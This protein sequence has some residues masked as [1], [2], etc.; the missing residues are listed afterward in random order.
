MISPLSPQPRSFEK[1]VSYIGITKNIEKVIGEIEEKT[2]IVKLEHLLESIWDKTLETS[3]LLFL[4][5]KKM[6][7]AVPKRTKRKNIV[8]W[9]EAKNRD[10]ESKIIRRV[11]LDQNN[12]I[13]LDS[14]ILA[15]AI[16][17]YKVDEDEGIN[18]NNKN[19]GYWILSRTSY[20]ERVHMIMKEAFS[21][22]YLEGFTHSIVKVCFQGAST[23]VKRS[24]YE[25]L[26]LPGKQEL[27]KRAEYL[28]K[29]CG[30]PE[31]DIEG[32]AR[33]VRCDVSVEDKNIK[34]KVK[35]LSK[36]IIQRKNTDKDEIEYL[37]RLARRIAVQGIT[38][39]N[40]ETLDS[41][42]KKGNGEKAKGCS[43]RIGA[44]IPNAGILLQY[45]H[46]KGK[47]EACGWFPL[48]F[49][50]LQEGAYTLNAVRDIDTDEFGCKV[51]GAPLSHFKPRI[52]C[53]MIHKG[54]K[55]II[56]GEIYDLKALGKEEFK[57][58]ENMPLYLKV[59]P[60]QLWPL[61]G[62]KEEEKDKKGKKE[63]VQKPCLP[64]QMMTQCNK[65]IDNLNDKEKSENSSKQI[66]DNEISSD[67]TEDNEITIEQCIGEEKN[68]KGSSLIEEE[69]GK[70]ATKEKEKS[71]KNEEKQENNVFKSP[72]PP[73]IS[74]APSIPPIC[75]DFTPPDPS[76]NMLF[77]S[78]KM[79]EINECAQHDTKERE[80]NF[81]QNNAT[82]AKT[83]ADSIV[84]NPEDNHIVET[85]GII[86]N[87]L[88]LKCVKNNINNSTTEHAPTH[89]NTYQQL[90]ETSN[91]PPSL[92][93]IE[94]EE[95]EEQMSSYEN[96]KKSKIIDE[97]TINTPC[98]S[99]TINTAVGGNKNQVQ[100]SDL[101]MSRNEFEEEKREI[102]NL[103]PDLNKTCNTNTKTHNNTNEESS[104]Y[105]SII[106]PTN[107]NTVNSLEQFGTNKISLNENFNKNHWNDNCARNTAPV[108]LE[109]QV[110]VLD[111]GEE[112]KIIINLKNYNI[113]KKQ[114]TIQI[115]AP[116][117]N[118]KRNDASCD[119][120][121]RRSESKGDRGV[122]F[123]GFWPTGKKRGEKDAESE[124][125]QQRDTPK[126][127]KSNIFEAARRMRDKERTTMIY[128]S[129]QNESVA[130]GMEE[131][132]PVMIKRKGE[133]DIYGSGRASEQKE[134]VKVDRQHQWYDDVWFK[135]FDKKEL[136][137]SEGFATRKISQKLKEKF[138]NTL[139]SAEDGVIERMWLNLPNF[140]MHPNQKEL[141]EMFSN[142]ENENLNKEILAESQFYKGSWGKAYKT[143]M[144]I[145]EGQVG[146][147]EED[148]K[149]LFP[150]CESNTKE[151]MQYNINVGNEKRLITA[152]EIKNTVKTLPNGKA[153]GIS[154][155]SYEVIKSVAG[156]KKGREAIARMYN[157]A[158]F[159]PE[160]M[161][162]QIYTSKC[163]G[164]PKKTGGVRPLCMQ[165]AIIKPLH[166][167]ISAKI[168][169]VVRKHIENVQKCLSKTEGQIC[170]WERVMSEVEKNKNAVIIQFDFSN[171]F[172][173]I[174]RG[175]IIKRLI[176]YR[177]PGEF[178]NYIDKMLKRQ[179]IIYIGKDNIDKMKVINRGV[180]QGEPLSM[181]L[182]ALGIDEMLQNIENEAKANVTAYADDV[183]LVLKDEENIKGIIDKFVEM[184]KQRGLSV[185][186]QKTKIGYRKELNK[187]IHDELKEMG[188]ECIDIKKDKLEYLSLP[189][190]VNKEM[191][192]K[193]VKE[194]TKTFVEI[195]EELWSK[196]I[197]TQMKY[198]LQEICINSKMIYVYKAIPLNNNENKKAKWMK[199]M[200]ERIDAIWEK[201]FNK[202][203]KIWWRIPV[204]L[205][206][207]GLFN[208][209]DR[210]RIARMSYE[211][212]KNKKEECNEKR[213]F[214]KEYFEKKIERWIEKRRIQ[215]IDLSAL[216][217]YINT[218]LLSPPTE[219]G[220][221]L[222]N[223]AFRL[224]VETRYCSNGM[225]LYKKGGIGK[226]KCK[227]SVH[228]EPWT[229]Q[230]IISCPLSCLQAVRSQHDRLVQYVSGILLR[231]HKVE[232]VVRERK[233]IEQER[234]MKEGKES[235]RA[236]ITYWKDG[237][238]HSL[239]ISVTTSWSKLKWRNTIKNRLKGKEKEYREEENVHILLFDTSGGIID[240]AWRLLVGL[241]ASSYDM[242]RLQTII[243]RSNARRYQTICMNC[244]NE[245]YKMGKE[246]EVEE[247]RNKEKGKDM[248]VLE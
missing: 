141:N 48:K 94:I 148:I 177:I 69:R 64:V 205:Y 171:A 135:I 217:P 133:I 190:S 109:P 143:L 198:H 160:E 235:K 124:W 202:E 81:A 70:E 126:G 132:L 219:Q 102:N 33:K 221:K 179:R 191:F 234:R 232:N 226:R 24:I 30:I 44:Y 131:N 194:K 196:D 32:R 100:N 3:L 17:K 167:I 77:N 156:M 157:H 86:A 45:T 68:T 193:H 241:G 51:I 74:S 5:S 210:R 153:V 119:T 145:N 151:N 108:A 242:R 211:W 115:A 11:I 56:N 90:Q 117:L 231:S 165:E 87:E 10:E 82:D 182:F 6:V 112:L 184:S 206:G 199:R 12:V 59:E 46:A 233:T 2:M 139:S 63:I 18:Q 239:D 103:P 76:Q 146:M 7:I 238:Q 218:T 42:W 188:I 122:C 152:K 227:C 22:G 29:I 62:D 129:P 105:M 222:D 162:P 92:K 97:E 223:L 121:A 186:M 27:K 195:T 9:F 23:N 96:R 181:L 57:G 110:E 197:T 14:S 54:K 209:I 214:W 80:K 41:Q 180:P 47:S 75:V 229:L 8:Q 50:R 34:E 173:T 118:D 79:S 164:I 213:E 1:G 134:Y 98:T 125:G 20:R 140:L 215:K 114:I 216:P 147:S 189:I 127:S 172:G 60:Y 55:K 37:Q 78:E 212:R 4:E 43:Y 31:K 52:L 170:A 95:F 192:E 66:T 35:S 107:K 104:E 224:M 111:S 136:Y 176:D 128:K 225:N 116:G 113:S 26:S 169:A 88:N 93:I 155:C 240:N 83:A 106:C 144:G 168:E 166:K 237:K 137:R 58:G 16:V 185:N 120:L 208:I 161:H 247:R 53:F 243:F 19:D 39:E 149:R 163:V 65:A 101:E 38:K 244:K 67:G 71:G 61:N 73:L 85:L 245:I 236:D 159:H 207:L 200:Q 248:N 15:I 142:V 36:Y 246:K 21:I 201:Y 99:C 40:M 150:S 228:N 25:R 154:G 183:V 72:S 130:K 178:I 123:D 220:M 91:T 89:E 158:I 49:G 84:M 230:H 13:E 28:E 138:V 204:K 187:K 203:N 175:Y 174:D